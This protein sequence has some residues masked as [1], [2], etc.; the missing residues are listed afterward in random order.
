MKKTL[1]VIAAAIVLFFP[2]CNIWED[3]SLC[4]SILS[5]DCSLLEGKALWADIWIFTSEGNLV[6]RTRI[7]EHEFC[8]PQLF[9]VEKGE[10]KC[11]VWAN[12]GEA[13]LT[14]D[15]NTYNGI[16]HKKPGVDA[17]QLYSFATVKICSKEREY[18]KVQPKKMF[19]DV[20]VTVKGL[21]SGENAALNLVS[22]YGGYSLEGKAVKQESSIDSQTQDKLLMRM[23]RPELLDGLNI[24]VLFSFKNGETLE[25]NFDL[26]TYLKNSGYDLSSDDLK[27]V[28]LTIDVSRL[29]AGIY[30]DP[31]DKTPPV[32]I[33]F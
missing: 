22:D 25:S 13:T 19:I 15:I 28:M 3:R 27:D 10:Y 6:H 12:V 5:V 8:N 29:K 4:P 16:L 32:V 33:N 24:K 9:E 14:T 11:F 1:L 31:F 26:G 7:T 2:S 21:V 18:V 23:L 20:Y 30:V 17:D